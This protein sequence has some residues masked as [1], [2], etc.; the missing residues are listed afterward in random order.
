MGR[1]KAFEK[2]QVPIIFQISSC[3]GAKVVRQARRNDS[4]SEL[5][6]QQPQS[7]T[8]AQ[9][10]LVHCT[11]IARVLRDAWKHRCAAVNLLAVGRV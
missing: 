2:A 4:A 7:P 5:V 8:A 1:K 3:R 6:Q 11:N 10:S 9:I